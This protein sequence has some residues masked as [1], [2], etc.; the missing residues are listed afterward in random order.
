[1]QGVLTIRLSAQSL[2]ALRDRARGEGKTASEIVRVL[3]ENETGAPAPSAYEMSRRWVGSVRSP[4]PVSR[5][6]NAR[7]LLKHWTPD[8]RG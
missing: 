2:R 8:R 4:R 5:G 3:I 6:R 1:M 7:K